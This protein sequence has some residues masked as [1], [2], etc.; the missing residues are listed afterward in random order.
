MSDV[1]KIVSWAERKAATRAPT[2]GPTEP[3]LEGK[4]AHLTEEEK[5]AIRYAYLE[6]GGTATF[7]ELGVRFNR[8]RETIAA[9]CKG[10]EFQKLRKEFEAEVRHTA[11]AK[12]KSLTLPAVQ[13][14]ETAIPIAAEKG[15]VRP[16]ERLL[17]HVGIMEDT[18]SGKVGV[19]V[20]TKVEVNGL[21][22]VKGSDGNVY[23]TDPDT[24]EIVNLPNAGVV[25]QVGC[26]TLKDVKIGELSATPPD[27]IEGEVVD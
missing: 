25:M 3:K 16:A 9:C 23:E 22:M 14:F 11:I 18:E 24:G 15:D 12:L 2:L 6:A 10:P 5:T 4:A 26:L 20:L 13:A 21:P 27:A 19:L 17:K 7:K 1:D 8:N